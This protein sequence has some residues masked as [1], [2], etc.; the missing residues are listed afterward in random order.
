MAD[1][2]TGNL[3]DTF[4]LVSFVFGFMFL[5][6]A[7]N[8]SGHGI[9]AFQNINDDTNIPD[10]GDRGLRF[11]G[12]YVGFDHACVQAPGVSGVP[13]T[14]CSRI[15]PSKERELRIIVPLTWVLVSFALAH[16][17]LKKAAN[18][19]KWDSFRSFLDTSIMKYFTTFV[20]FLGPIALLVPFLMFWASFIEKHDT[21]T[22]YYDGDSDD[23][24]TGHPGGV[25]TFNAGADKYKETA[26][27][28][29]G[30]TPYVWLLVVGQFCQ[31]AACLL[32]FYR[33]IQ[34]TKRSASGMDRFLIDSEI[35]KGGLGFLNEKVGTAV[36][37][38]A[39]NP[40]TKQKVTSVY[41]SRRVTN[42]MQ[43]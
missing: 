5:M 32:V 40:E 2:D 29:G 24:L 43:F 11:R 23:V 6:D 30:M 21:L 13:Y 37:A 27:F 33:N 36:D 9:V 7:Y 16:V 17:L 8:Q 39:K 4:F 14:D 3:I 19:E 22:K 12:N 18:R 26:F 1:F 41:A 10:G 31:T 42:G 25:E 20:L 38:A 28:G 15:Q 34:F 35:F